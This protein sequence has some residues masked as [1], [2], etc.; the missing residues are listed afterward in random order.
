MFGRKMNKLKSKSRHSLKLQ[1]W[2]KY[3]FTFC[4]VI[5]KRNSFYLE[6]PAYVDWVQSVLCPSTLVCHKP[7]P[8]NASWNVPAHVDVTLNAHE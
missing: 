3:V 6:F 5:M 1:D 4:I 2:K 8:S 7:S